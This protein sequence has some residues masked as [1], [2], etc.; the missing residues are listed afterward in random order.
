M[1]FQSYA[2]FPHMSVVENVAYGLTVKFIPKK[3]TRE[4]AEYGLKWQG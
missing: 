3:E 4:K 2:F 1:V